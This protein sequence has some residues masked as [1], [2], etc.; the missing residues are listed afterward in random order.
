MD[1]YYV[2]QYLRED[3]TPYYIGKG[4]GNRAFSDSHRV[5]VPDDVSRIE[6]IQENLSESDALS[7]EIELIAKFGRKDLGTGILR[8]LT[9][10]GDGLKNPGPET[11][12]KMSDNV[13][14]GITG[15]LGKTHS[16]STKKKMSDAAKKKTFTEEH[17]KKI[18]DARRGKKEDPAVGKR[19]GEAISK[20]KKGK[21]NGHEGMK[22]SE[23]TKAKISAQKG[24]KHSDEAKEKMRGRPMTEETKQ[25]IRDS[26][27]TTRQLKKESNH[28]KTV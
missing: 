26:L 15:M 28:G 10:G 8:N 18:G 25:K 13:R 7:L 5:K 1:I 20:A 14:R 16:D 21:S 6:I 23:E 9:S 2:Y 17:R 11:R 3:G 19:R 22:H 27:R 24:W 4:Y 12:K